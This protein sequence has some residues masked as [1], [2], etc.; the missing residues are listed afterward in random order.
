MK[1]ELHDAYAADYNA[2]VLAY[3][4]H[5]TDLL[6]GLSYEFIRPGQRLLDAG[7]GSGLSST[8]AAKAGLEVHGMDFSPAMLEVCRAKGFAADLKLHDLQHLPWVYSLGRVR[9]PGLLW[10]A[11]L[12][13]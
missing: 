9:S 1:A 3:D 2:E 8:L 12:H 4:C 10:G 5:I 11:A 13:R 6:F 7:I